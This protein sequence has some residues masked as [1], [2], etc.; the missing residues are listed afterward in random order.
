[1]TSCVDKCCFFA[2]SWD[3][4]N[5]QRQELCLKCGGFWITPVPIDRRQRTNNDPGPSLTAKTMG[6]VWWRC[7]SAGSIY[8]ADTPKIPK[9]LT[10]LKTK[11]IPGSTKK[12]SSW[13]TKK[14][15]VYPTASWNLF[16]LLLEVLD[17]GL[18]SPNNI[19][20]SLHV[21][22]NGYQW[23]SSSL[24]KNFNFCLKKAWDPCPDRVA[25]IIQGCSGLFSLKFL[26]LG[27]LLA[28][29]PSGQPPSQD[30][31]TRLYILV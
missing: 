7:W 8:F 11:Q 13:P 28:A 9:D 12:R 1:M 18:E 2:K 22:T 15:L 25:L 27:S 3:L 21:L 6:E 20:K 17:E 30:S 23:W 24:T 10:F 14:A 16:W 29:W 31:Y 5:S 4:R 26:D 19:G